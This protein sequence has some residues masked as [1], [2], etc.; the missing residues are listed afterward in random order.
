MDKTGYVQ[1]GL[2]QWKSA[3]LSFMKP[4][5]WSPASQKS[6]SVVPTYNSSNQVAKTRGL[7]VQGHPLPF[8]VQGQPQLRET[9]SQRRKV[10]ARKKI[11]M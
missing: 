5:V 3:Y 9:L 2:A 7:E 1:G 8:L 4:Q 10:G 11:Y 6:A